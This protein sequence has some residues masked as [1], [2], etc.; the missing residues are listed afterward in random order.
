MPSG[1]VTAAL[2]TAVITGTPGERPSGTGLLRPPTHSTQMPS[3]AC[4]VLDV[5]E[6]SCSWV[7]P[8]GQQMP[9]IAFNEANIASIR[10][11]ANRRTYR[12]CAT[13]GVV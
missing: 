12:L 9:S 3:P 13:H 10:T 6:A 5:E 4:G 8:S 2:A 11:A 7:Q 1:I